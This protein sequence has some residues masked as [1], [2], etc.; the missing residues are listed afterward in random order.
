MTHFDPI[1]TIALACLFYGPRGVSMFFLR[2]FPLADSAGNV[3]FTVPKN[4]LPV[5]TVVGVA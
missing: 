4:C 3:W 5:Y 1:G 2:F